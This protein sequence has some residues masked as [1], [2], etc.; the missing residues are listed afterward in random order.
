MGWTRGRVEGHPVCP[1]KIQE[2]LAMVVLYCSSDI[3]L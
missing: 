1:V 2:G 3:T